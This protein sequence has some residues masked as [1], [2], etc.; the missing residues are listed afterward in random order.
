MTMMRKEVKS[1]GKKEMLLGLYES[2]KRI[3][4]IED[5]VT[6]GASIMETVAELNKVPIFLIL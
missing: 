4:I 2:G 1:H 5:V 3:V 6:S